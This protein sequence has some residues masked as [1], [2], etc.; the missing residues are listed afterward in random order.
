MAS[1]HDRFQTGWRVDTMLGYAHGLPSGKIVLVNVLFDL[2]AH[3][4]FIAAYIENCETF[5]DDAKELLEGYRNIISG[6]DESLH[7]SD[8][9]KLRLTGD[10]E[11]YDLTE[12]PFSGRVFLY[13][14]ETLRN[15]ERAAL[16]DRGRQLN[17]SV[18][19]R[20]RTYLEQLE[21]WEKPTLFISHDSRNKDLIARPLADELQKRYRYRVWID[22]Y[23]LRVGDSLRESIE[24]GLKEC[25]VCVLILTREFLSNSAWAK[26]EFD[27]IFTREM[28]ER[29][30]FIFPVW[31]GITARDVYE[32]SPSLA[33][34]KGV[35]WEQGIE[36]V[37]WEINRALPTE[38]GGRIP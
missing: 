24:R 35:S 22:D 17:L 1:M 36:R 28:V 19:I 3:S 5:I 31:C 2:E 33:D 13:F 32:Y 8:E 27:S 9:N 18:V 12:I 34:K 20:D 37:A 6:V 16:L 4:K 11:A 25:K 15:H 26:K 29:G 23:A 7:R 14:D 21:R 10:L 30:A 38:A